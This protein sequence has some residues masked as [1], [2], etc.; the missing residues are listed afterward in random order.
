[1]LH[2]PTT[3]ADLLRVDVRCVTLCPSSISHLKTLPVLQTS[4]TCG[5]TF[6]CTQS[7][8]AHQDAKTCCGTVLAVPW[9]ALA[10][11]RPVAPV[12]GIL[13][14]CPLSSSSSGTRDTWLLGPP[15]CA[16]LHPVGMQKARVRKGSNKLDTPLNKGR[17]SGGEG[18]KAAGAR[19]AGW[20]SRRRQ[21]YG[22]LVSH[23]ASPGMHSQSTG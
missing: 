14:A 12:Q 5:Q 10:Q 6:A 20:L 17:W 9:A 8:E 4:C 13:A 3:V 7:S 2:L 18:Q 19:V 21:R 15:P 1:M 22:C 11:H 16:H 23:A